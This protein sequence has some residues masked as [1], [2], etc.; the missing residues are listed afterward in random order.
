MHVIQLACALSGRSARSAVRDAQHGSR[1]RRRGRAVRTVLAAEV[2][3]EV[4]AVDPCV[5][6]MSAAISEDERDAGPG[7]RVR[8]SG[9]RANRAQQGSGS[10][11]SPDAVQRAA[12]AEGFAAEPG[13]MLRWVP[14]LRSS[15]K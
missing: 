5:D 7:Y 8:A 10:G 15:G 11:R 3:E 4:G 9:L 1:G 2:A 13:S 12:L 6:R 14:A